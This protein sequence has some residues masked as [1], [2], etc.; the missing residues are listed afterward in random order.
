MT[1]K[2][3]LDNISDEKIKKFISI[4]MNPDK[5]ERYKSLNDLKEA[6]WNL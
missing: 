2:I 1:G 4:G 3:N 6:F 5:S